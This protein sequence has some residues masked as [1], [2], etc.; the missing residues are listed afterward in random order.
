MATPEDMPIIFR[1]RKHSGTEPVYGIQHFSEGR[2]CF[3]DC[4]YTRMEAENLLDHYSRRYPPSSR[5]RWRL[6]MI[7]YCGA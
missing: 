6:A 4:A 7:V 5:G 2:W 1:K 3:L